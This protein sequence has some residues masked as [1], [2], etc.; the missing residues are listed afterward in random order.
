MGETARNRMA[1]LLALCVAPLLIGAS[2]SP[3]FR[4]LVY[5][6]VQEG[7]PLHTVGL[8][9][10]EGF[11]RMALLNA[12]DKPIAKVA[13]AAVE[14]APPGCGAEPR[15][16]IHV[17]GSVEALDIPPHGTV[18]TPPR[19]TAPG[20]PAAVLIANAKRLKAASLHVQIVVM[21]V[22]FEDGTKWKSQKQLP[23]T[24]FDSSLADA[25]A[26]KCSDASA[27]TEALSLTDGVRFDRGVERPSTGDKDEPGST[28][29]LSFYCSLEGSKA[30]CP[31]P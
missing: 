13:I 7:S 1:A 28:P 11:I 30:V 31:S 21:E 25:D 22:D 10:D 4:I 2:A 20:I 26:G 23:A 19:G 3:I 14:V 27:V 9:Y 29:R 18:M 15:T 5:A 17:G 8:Q 12:S 16:R 24:P 6:P